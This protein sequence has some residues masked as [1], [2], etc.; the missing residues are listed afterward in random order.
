VE[1]AALAP[2]GIPGTVLTQAFEGSRQ[3]YEVD[4]KDVRLR[5]EMLT[6]AANVRRLEPGDR[7][8]VEVAPE[9]SVLLPDG[10]AAG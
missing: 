1:E 5:V 7:V 4:I 9:S 8:R 10:D 2:G 6:A 3:V